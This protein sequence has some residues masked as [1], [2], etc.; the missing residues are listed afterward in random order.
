MKRRLLELLVRIF[1]YR[2]KW[3]VPS[4]GSSDVFFI[5]RN[6][7]LGDVLM[8][9]PLLRALRKCHPK[10]TILVGCGDWAKD[11]LLNNPDV[12]E[13][14]QVNAPWHNKQICEYPA[15]SIQGFFES[16]KYIF[17]SKEVR[18]LRKRNINY[19]IDAL[20]SP[21][22][23]FLMAAANIPCRLGIK[24]YAG[25]HSGCSGYVQ[26]DEQL[27]VGESLLRFISLLGGDLGE[28]TMPIIHL[29]SE[30]RAYGQGVWSRFKERQKC[31][32]IIIAPGA[33]FIEK[34]WGIES[35][36]LLIKALAKDRSNQIVIVGSRRD[37]DFNED[38]LSRGNNVINL[39]GETS[40]RETFSVV[41]CANS[42]V[43]NS[44]LIMHVAGA[45]RLPNLVLLGDWYDSADL[46]AKQ[47]GHENSIV[48]GRET[49]KEKRSIVTVE[50]ALL[51]MIN[52]G[53]IDG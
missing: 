38:D 24:G 45:F 53:M 50:E 26:Y 52:N 7:D 6:N 10:A 27:H 40:L 37:F 8:I 28:D 29:T 19:G 21:E 17:F 1:C 4:V 9:T 20:G 39:C 36:F 43:C 35:Y 5:L 47:W 13:V 30:E 42:V 48:F 41:A 33:G 15:N 18:S 16:L 11:C 32:K 12:N 14:V 23:S 46:H 31:K 3:K 22:G 2:K 25:G 44:S 51:K 49:T 34:N